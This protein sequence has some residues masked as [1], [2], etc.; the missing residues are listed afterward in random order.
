MKTSGSRPKCD[1]ETQ[2][3]ITREFITTDISRKELAERYSVS[4]ATIDN[5]VRK[6]REEF[7]QNDR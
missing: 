4:L 7:E 6:Y 1:Y 3:E 5:Y 2:R